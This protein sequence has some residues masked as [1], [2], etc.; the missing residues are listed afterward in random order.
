MA[1]ADEQVR[2]DVLASYRNFRITGH[3]GPHTAMTAVRLHCGYAIADDLEAGREPSEGDWARYRT[4]CMYLN[5]WD[6]RPPGW[7]LW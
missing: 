7:W 2:R 4:A 6:R 1:E 3:M 5:T